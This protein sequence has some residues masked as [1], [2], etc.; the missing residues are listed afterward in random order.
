MIYDVDPFIRNGLSMYK[1]SKEITF[2]TLKLYYWKTIGNAK[3]DLN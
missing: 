3:V 2:A 1:A